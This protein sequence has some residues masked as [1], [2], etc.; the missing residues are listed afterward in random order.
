MNNL[1]ITTNKNI[2]YGN[3]SYTFESINTGISITKKNYYIYLIKIRM[4]K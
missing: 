3:V 2:N 4:E 1:I